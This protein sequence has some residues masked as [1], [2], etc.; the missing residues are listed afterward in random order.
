M[1]LTQ[2]FTTCLSSVEHFSFSFNPVVLLLW[3]TH[4]IE[5]F[6]FLISIIS[7]CNRRL[8]SAKISRNNSNSQKPNLCQTVKVLLANTGEHLTTKRLM[9]FFMLRISAQ[10]NILKKKC[11]EYRAYVLSTE[12]RK[13]LRC[14]WMCFMCVGKICF[15]VYQHW[16]N[17]SEWN[18]AGLRRAGSNTC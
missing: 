1:L 12:E 8:L 2:K 17:M 3:F 16:Q 9:G 6:F 13:Y 15:V 5:S 14:I 10:K 11:C 7:C 4:Q 18:K